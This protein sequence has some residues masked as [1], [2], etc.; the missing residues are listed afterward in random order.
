MPYQLCVFPIYDLQIVSIRTLDIG[1][2][3]S[4]ARG[5]ARNVDAHKGHLAACDAP[6]RNDL[7]TFW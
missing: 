4:V 1:A 5:L 2:V 7:A 3:W 6:R